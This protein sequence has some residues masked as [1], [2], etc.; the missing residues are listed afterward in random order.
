[1]LATGSHFWCQHHSIWMY[2]VDTIL[3]AL[4]SQPSTMTP[5]VN[6]LDG[7]WLPLGTQ[8]H[9]LRGSDAKKLDGHGA[10]NEEVLGSLVW[11]QLGSQ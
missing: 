9:C 4:R 7:T 5:R 1:M 2:L 6:W 10:E 8:R 11:R 3:E